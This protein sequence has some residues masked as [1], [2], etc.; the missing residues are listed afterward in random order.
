MN[1][2]PIAYPQY[3][4]LQ[5]PEGHQSD[6][7]SEG[8]GRAS[9]LGDPSR[10]SAPN[11]ELKPRSRALHSVQEEVEEYE[12]AKEGSSDGED[13]FIFKLAVEG[14]AKSK[15][16]MNFEH[17][18]DEDDDHS[19]RS[20]F[21]RE[22]D[23][24]KTEERKRLGLRVKRR[25]ESQGEDVEDSDEAS[26]D[27]RNSLRK[28]SFASRRYIASSRDPDGGNNS[29]NGP[30][31]NSFEVG[32]TLAKGPTTNSDADVEPWQVVGLLEG[33][34]KGIRSDDSA[35]SGKKGINT[36][37]AK[38]LSA[39]KEYGTERADSTLSNGYE[40]SD[41]YSVSDKNAQNSTIQDTFSMEKVTPRRRRAH[42]ELKKQNRCDNR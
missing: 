7:G 4:T 33:V 17:L 1:T 3:L 32:R 42:E 18:S 27:S 9:S 14:S 20:R 28:A 31:L 2:L 19:R 26:L 34:S 10:I 8:K 15:D 6:W 38:Q 22:K 16:Y 24:E 11:R 25:P 39:G 12:G 41:A 13:G 29:R 21:M 5:Q 23:E 35:A 30:N 40:S 36:I 37:S